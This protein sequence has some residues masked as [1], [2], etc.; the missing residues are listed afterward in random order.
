MQIKL[1]LY[2]KK[3]KLLIWLSVPLLLL[4]LSSFWQA[5]ASLQQFKTHLKLDTPI[6]TDLILM[7]MQDQW[8]Q[9]WRRFL[10]ANQQVKNLAVIDLSLP[11]KALPQL[12]EP[13]KHPFVPVK[14]AFQALEF[15]GQ[16]RLRGYKPWHVT[17]AKK[18]LRI[19]LKKGDFIL[20]NREFNLLNPDRPLLIE[21][22]MVFELAKAHGLITT[23][24][25]FLRLRFNGLDLGVFA[26]TT[27]LDEIVLRQNQRIPADLYTLERRQA[28]FESSQN[29]QY[30]TWFNSENKDFGPL[31]QFLETVKTSNEA[32]FAA[33][34]SQAL[35]LKS[36]AVL[37]VL[38]K[39]FAEPTE[40]SE[41]NYGLYFD[42]YKGQW[43]PVL[44]EFTGFGQGQAPELDNP[45]FQR[46]NQ[47]PVYQ[48][49]RAQVLAEMLQAGASSTSLKNKAQ[50]L[51]ALLGP[52]LNADPYWRARGLSSQTDPLYSELMRPMSLAKSEQVLAQKLAAIEVRKQALKPLLQKPAKIKQQAQQVLKWG[53]G[54]LRIE[55]TQIFSADQTVVIAAGTTLAMG[56]QASLIFQGPVKF[57]GSAE[58]KIQVLPSGPR[59]WGGLVLQ[60]PGTTGSILQGLIVRGGSFPVWPGHQYPGMINLHNSS[61]IT[62]KD[63][64]FS[65]NQASDDLLH[66]VYISNLKAERV[67]IT[68][69]FSD[70]WD[71]EFSQAQISDLQINQA[72]DDGLDLMGTD[73]QVEFSQIRACQGNGISAGE[74]SAVQVKQVLI[75]Q[76]GVG[77]LSKNGSQIHFQAS[78][79]FANQSGVKIYQASPHYPAWS[80]VTGQHLFISGHGRPLELDG[81]S[82][83]SIPAPEYSTAYQ[84]SQFLE[85]LRLGLKLKNWQNLPHYLQQVKKP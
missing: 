21:E 68:Q 60:G 70:A 19:K 79:L 5:W 59:R 44:F 22:K 82:Q 25:D 57:L 31:T 48:A 8:L 9:E 38:H 16:V 63:C 45:L 69:A 11:H 2:R 58:Q 27:P 29:W 40:D 41:L 52:D 12:L 15:K 39:L 62:L 67:Q 23:A 35:H 3:F 85:P 34:A 33:F 13:G 54:I 30:I 50:K 49:L 55:G 84:N 71:L 76:S 6:K 47:V 77:A 20:G 51:L 72:G 24:T 4:L 80:K 64:H 18:S 26:Y 81:I 17:E 7:R 10:P 61:K 75:A 14:I 43:E 66:S 78:L 56:P 32:E 53:P 28:G 73:L 46:L 42:P 37:E 65:D 74:G 83:K 1:N 36:F